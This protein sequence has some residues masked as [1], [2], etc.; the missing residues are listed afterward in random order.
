MVGKNRSEL[1]RRLNADLILNRITTVGIDP[2][3]MPSPSGVARRSNWFSRNIVHGIIMPIMG[4]VIMWLYPE[5]NGKM[6]TTTRSARD[7]IRATMDISVAKAAYFD[8][9]ARV[10]TAKEAQD[11]MK[12]EIIWRDSV[13]Y[14]KLKEGETALND[15]R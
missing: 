8:G 1:Q 3:S 4:Y 15:W 2:G 11:I 13:R 7:V 10:Q 14:S 9:T 12:R 6:R 5:T